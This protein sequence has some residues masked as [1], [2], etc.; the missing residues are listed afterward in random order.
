VIVTERLAPGAVAR[1]VALRHGIHAN[2]LCACRR[3]VVSLP[4]ASSREGRHFAPM[5]LASESVVR[6]I[7]AR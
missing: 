6:W 1:S 3:E 7:L 2:Q 5:T 4:A